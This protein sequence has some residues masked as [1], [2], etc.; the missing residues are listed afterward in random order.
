M[1]LLDYATPESAE[2]RVAEIYGVFP[3]HVGVPAPLQLLS[4]SPGLLTAQMETLKHYMTHE[5]LSF[6]L[7]AAIRCTVAVREGYDDC[8]QLNARLLQAAGAGEEE[9]EQ[10]KAD[11]AAAPMLEEPE[12]A[13]L[14]FV[15]KAL[16]DPDAVGEA[17]VAALRELG[18][19]DADIL[20]AMAHGANMVAAAKIFRTFSR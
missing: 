3:P 19:M 15:H 8:V 4:A 14:G 20:D 6:P 12:R 9:I 16:D 1:F 7:L 10:A 2:G 17:D 11:P 5:R 18:W 13:V